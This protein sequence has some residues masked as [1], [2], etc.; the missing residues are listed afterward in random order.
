Y[1]EHL[2]YFSV[3]SLMRLCDAVGLSIVAIEHVSVHGGSIRMYARDKHGAEG[4]ATDVLSI[5]DQERQGGLQDFQTYVRF[6]ETVKATRQKLVSLLEDLKGQGKS[7]AA[8]GAPAKGNTLLNYCAI[9]TRLVS[10]TVDKNPLKVGLYTPGAHL[11][12]LPVPTLLER[13]PDYVLILAWNFA[14]E[15]MQQQ[16]QYRERGGRFI[17][18]IPEPRIGAS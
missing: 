2:C 18:P 14:E 12:V 10:Y 5:V 15:I 4:H 13:Q 17:I 3:T 16:H 7:V 1:H 9:D 6:A 8:Y 11:P